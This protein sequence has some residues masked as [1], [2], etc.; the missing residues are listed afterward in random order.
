MHAGV[1]RRG[2]RGHLGEMT[3]QAHVAG[4]QFQRALRKADRAAGQCRDLRRQ[5][6]VAGRFEICGVAVPPAAVQAPDVADDELRLV[7]QRPQPGRLENRGI[8]LHGVD[9]V[10]QPLACVHHRQGLA[11]QNI[12][13]VG[14]G[15]QHLTDTRRA[16]DRQAM[17]R[18]KQLCAL[19]R[20]VSHRPRPFH[21]IALHLLGVPRVG[22]VP[23]EEVPGADRLVARY[24]RPCVVI[25]LALG[26]AQVDLQAAN[27]EAHGLA[28]EG[29]GLRRGF[30]Q[31]GALSFQSIAGAP[32]L[33]ELALVDDPVVAVGQV[34]AVEP[35]RHVL[36]TTDAGTRMS[37][38]LRVLNEGAAAAHVIQMAVR[39]DDGVEAVGPPTA[40]FLH[41][42]RAAKVIGRIERHQAVVGLKQYTM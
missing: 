9:D 35:L 15:F 20:H 42:P 38:T 34:I 1:V 11:D 25:G 13:R 6:A 3:G 22:K 12:E 10:V 24:P 5:R 8:D 30:R 39:V 29:V 4:A 31:E 2:Q 7:V 14:H 41:D 33:A 23:D 16:G 17:R 27:T 36:V 19:R 37:M 28:V 18:Q 40:D 26:M 21:R 32:E